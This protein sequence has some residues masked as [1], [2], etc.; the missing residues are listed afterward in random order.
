MMDTTV[1]P[2]VN[3][4]GAD[5]AATV[6]TASMPKIRGKVTDGEKPLRVKI[7]EWLTPK[8]RTVINVQPGLTVGVGTSVYSSTSGP[9]G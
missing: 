4:S 8:P 2:T 3:R 1:W 5:V 7:S 6:P 9:P